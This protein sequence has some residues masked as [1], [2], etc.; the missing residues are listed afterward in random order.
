M[1][2]PTANTQNF[3]LKFFEERDAKVLRLNH[4]IRV[5]N[6][7]LAVGIRACNVQLTSVR[8]DDSVKGRARHF[9]NSCACYI[10]LGIGVAEV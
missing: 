3:Q 1:V 5:H 9:D 8:N 4:F 6:P 7:K 2:R 10:L